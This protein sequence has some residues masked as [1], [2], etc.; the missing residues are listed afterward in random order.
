LGADCGQNERDLIKNATRVAPALVGALRS[1][2]RLRAPIFV[3]AAVV[4]LLLIS[5][6][7]TTF[8]GSATWDLNPV[9]ANWNIAT[10]WT[11]ATV[12]NSSA[13]TATFNLS[14][15]TGVSL[16]AATQING[17]VFKAGASA[18]TI[19]ASPS[20]TLIVSGAGITNNSG[21]PQNFVAPVDGAG[22]HGVFRFVNSAT[23]GSGT[24]FTTNGPVTAGAGG[25]AVLFENT[26]TAANG[27]FTN[28]ASAV[29]STVGGVTEFLNNSTAANGIFINNGSTVIGAGGGIVFFLASSTAGN[30]T[31]IANGGHGAV[32]GGS[33]RF[34]EG[35]S[36]GGTARV[37]VFGN[38]NMDISPHNA[39]GV[40]VGSIEGSGDIFLGANNLTVGSKDVSTTFSGLI[41]DGGH[42][43]AAG[44]S[45]TKI[46]TGTLTLTKANTYTGGTTIN[47]G[48]LLIK[49]KRDSA[50]GS[51]FVHVNSGTL[52]GAGTIAG[53]VTVGTGSGPGAS[54]SPGI[55][56]AVPGTLTI[57]KKLTLKADATY[58]FGLKSD[59]ATADKIVAKGV[60]IGSGA[61]FFF[62][63]LSSGALTP[64]TVFTVIDNTAAIPIAGTFSNLADGS[65]FTDANGNTFEVSYEGGTGND[66]TLT[67]V[68]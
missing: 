54:L 59:N 40:T 10:N 34:F 53:A 41:Q 37:E 19:T 18:F 51:S 44:G 25:G 27:T 24:V 29:A 52:G 15:V 20:F 46:G 43:G 64:G 11:P 62:A 60:S 12:P 45:L 63:D 47:S 17:I 55:S 33:I 13:D 2:L 61:Q 1:A 68:P 22:G 32:G 5:A 66:L 58:N 50:T 48:T 49:N 23:A 6:R 42:T 38:G 9:S 31:L 57:Q 8:A 14:N 3:L 28:N 56:S 7:N 65:T 39:P 16:S 4:L 26:S 30:A 35:D 21:I 36:T 67:V